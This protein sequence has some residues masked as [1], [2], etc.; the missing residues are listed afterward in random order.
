[1]STIDKS[2]VNRDAEKIGYRPI[3]D[4]T[5]PRSFVPLE[6]TGSEIT[7]ESITL[8]ELITY[9]PSNIATILSQTLA[10]IEDMLYNI[11]NEIGV[12]TSEIKA[13]YENQFTLLGLTQISDQFYDLTGS[14]TLEIYEQL[15]Y[16]KKLAEDFRAI[17]KK[18]YY[19]DPFITD[20]DAI[21]ED[22]NYFGILSEKEQTE[23]GSISYL[24]LFVNTRLLYI[25]S[26]FTQAIGDGVLQ[27]ERIRERN[28][29]VVDLSKYE[30]G[31]TM[32]NEQFEAVYGSFI[33]DS[34]SSRDYLNETI[35]GD[36]MSRSTITALNSRS[37][38]V[39]SHLIDATK[40]KI[41]EQYI[42]SY[43]GKIEEQMSRDTANMYRA[44]LNFRMVYENYL[45]YL[46]EKDVLRSIYSSSNQ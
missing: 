14:T 35:V 19:G 20:L 2:Q 13:L 30:N 34:R 37:D 6:R 15:V 45:G 3:L 4:Y 36:F 9:S 16:L 27:L 31:H 46:N 24:N 38:F 26:G 21:A 42:E 7:V 40:N 33:S 1:M 32:S 22:N 8:Q 23:P 18:A 39:Q 11:D 29:R 5:K 41:T 17:I 10:K 44:A 28:G 43:Q 12:G 25:G